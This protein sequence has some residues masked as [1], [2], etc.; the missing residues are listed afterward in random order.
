MKAVIFNH[1]GGP[2]VLEY[3]D[4]VTPRPKAGEIRV[5][6][7]AASVNP[8]DWKVRMGRLKFITGRKFPQYLGGEVA[9]II[10]STGSDV[11]VLKPGMR[12]FAGL[13]YKGG[14]YAEYA[15]MPAKNAV[16]LPDNIPFEEACTFAIA[17]ITPLQAMRDHAGIEEGMHVL[18]NGAS[19]GVGTYAVQIAKLLGARVTGVCSSRN[20]DLVTS[21][22]ADEVIDY[23]LDDFT[24]NTQTYDA[25]ID[26]VGNKTFGQVKSALKK[27]GYL[28]KLNHSFRTY[29]AQAWTTL[30]S[31]KKTKLVLLKNTT[32]D[33]KWIR[34]QV[35]LGKIKVIIDRTYPLS[36]AR[37]AHEYSETGR[38][39]GKIVLVSD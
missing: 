1:Y 25:I 9:G 18:V 2:E 6:V 37:K 3:T 27:H 26:A 17:G 30:F 35:A 29:F 5:S 36:E 4:V 24:L 39:R 33:V 31:S 20:A 13:S 22:G 16:V 7:K 32:H 21:L 10:E 14:G 11:K 38:A 8:V 15:C 34:D 28:I 12:V 19:G 23:G